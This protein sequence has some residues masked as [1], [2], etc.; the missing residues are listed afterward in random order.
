MNFILQGKVLTQNSTEIAV[1]LILT[2]LD[3]NSLT[4]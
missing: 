3:L 1:N 4:N 2:A